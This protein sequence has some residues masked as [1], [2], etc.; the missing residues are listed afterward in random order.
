MAIAD[1]E[2]IQRQDFALQYCQ[3]QINWYE[4]TK[5]RHRIGYQV[6]QITIVI[7]SLLSLFL[8]VFTTDKLIQAL[9]AAA[10]VIAI[11]LNSIFQPK[12]HYIRFAYTSE[13]LKDHL[14]KYRTRTTMYRDETKSEEETLDTFIRAISMIT[15]NEADAWRTRM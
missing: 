12:E 7:T 2:F 15:M 11:V 8:V 4:T 3:D 5:F 1:A 10:V 9:G 13:M 14:L 6:L